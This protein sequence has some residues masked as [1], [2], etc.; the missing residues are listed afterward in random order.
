MDWSIPL[1]N[2]KLTLQWVEE[3]HR[4]VSR[5][6]YYLGNQL[7]DGSVVVIVTRRPRFNLRKIQFSFLLDTEGHRVAGRIRSIKN[8]MT[9][10]EIEP[11]T[12]PLVLVT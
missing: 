11:A 10:S 1:K 9:S 4:A 3:S 6:P 7:A 2:V 8:P 5:L 12:F